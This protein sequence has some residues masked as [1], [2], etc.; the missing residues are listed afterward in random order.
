MD[1]RLIVNKFI[2]EIL[3]TIGFFIISLIFILILS[4]IFI[5]ISAFL[6][7]E[8]IINL[9][10]DIIIISILIFGSGFIIFLIILLIYEWLKSEWKNAKK[11]G[12]K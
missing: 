6:I 12:D 5:I 3:K 11:Q 9:I 1:K 7:P 2:K 10:L 8:F 4:G